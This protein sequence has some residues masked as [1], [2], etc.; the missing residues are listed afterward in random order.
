MCGERQKGRSETKRGLGEGAALVP[1]QAA[2]VY[3]G[4]ALWERDHSCGSNGPSVAPPAPRTLW[5][6]VP[7]LD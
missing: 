2:Q 6:H 7:M 1:E 4:G 3:T 5:R